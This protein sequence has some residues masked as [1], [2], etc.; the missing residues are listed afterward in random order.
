MHCNH[1]QIHYNSWTVFQLCQQN[2]HLMEDCAVQNY[3][4][5]KLEQL[6][7][8]RMYLQVTTLAKIT[9]HMGT[10]LLPQ[11][12][13]DPN[14]LDLCKLD[15]ISSSL[16]QWPT[17]TIPLAACWCIWLNTIWTIYTGSRMGTCL[18]QP[19]GPWLPT[20]AQQCFWKWRMPDHYHL[21]FQYSPTAPTRVGLQTQQ[22]HSMLK[23]SPMTPLLLHLTALL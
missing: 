13:P 15:T 1:T 5:V 20:Y 18:Q 7:T 3:S 21:L 9:D 22:R 10:K 12:F 19:L 16:L 8:C 2:R 4:T 17:I 11:A 6:N 23:F 14:Q